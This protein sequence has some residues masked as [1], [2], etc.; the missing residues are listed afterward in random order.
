VFTATTSGGVRWSVERDARSPAA[1][2]A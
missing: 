2:R 1:V